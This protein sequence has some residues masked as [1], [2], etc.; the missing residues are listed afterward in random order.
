MAIGVHLVAEEGNVSVATFEC[1]ARSVWIDGMLHRAQNLNMSVVEDVR[2]IMQDFLAPELRALAMRFDVVDSKFAALEARMDGLEAK[3]DGKL[4]AVNQRID[5]LANKIDS[6]EANTKIRLDGIE[7]NIQIR[8]AHVDEKFDR[9]EEKAA[10]RQEILMIQFESMKN[11]LNIDGR[12]RLLE[13]RENARNLA[14]SL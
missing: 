7:K 5:T 10:A 3:M 14:Q 1:A 6:I 2:Q 9:V 11:Q 13:T 4:D 8:F 12:V